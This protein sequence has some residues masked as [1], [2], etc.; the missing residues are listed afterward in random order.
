MVNAFLGKK[1]GMTQIFDQSGNVVPVTVVSLRGWYITQIKTLENDGYKAIQLGLL[2]SKYEHEDFRH[3]W[4][5][6]KS[7]FFYVFKEIYADDLQD[8]KVGQ[9]L[10]L[11]FINCKK[12]DLIKVSGVTK[13]KGFQGVVKRWNFSGGPMSHGSKFHR[14]PGSISYMRTE[15]EVSKGKKMPGRCGNKEVTLKGLKII[16]I[17]EDSSSIFIK[18]ALPGKRNT[19]FRIIKQGI[20]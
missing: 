9:L 8:L 4:L 7:V 18:G 14:N 19:V 11:N 15:G 10:A 20:L 3:D 1:I 2:K 16:D 6:K 13:G 5:K 17:H 12:G